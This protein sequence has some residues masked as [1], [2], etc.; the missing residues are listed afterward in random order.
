MLQRERADSSVAEMF[1]R[2]LL[3]VVF[4]FFLES[5]F[6]ST[7]MERTVEGTH[8]KFLRQI[9]GKRAW[10]REDGTWFIPETEKVRELTG[11]KSGKTYIGRI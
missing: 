1:Y 2:V 9:T 3:Q 11:T 10:R 5:L 7:E 4:L 8:T 6:L